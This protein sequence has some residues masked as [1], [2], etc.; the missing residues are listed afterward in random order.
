M[1]VP[2]TDDVNLPK[3]KA[4]KFTG[5]TA[6][7]LMFLQDDDNTADKDEADEVAGTYNGAMG[8]YRCDGDTACTVNIDA[9]GAITEIS[10]GWVFTPDPRV[11]SDVADANYLSYGFWLMK[12]TDEDGVLTYNEVETFAAVEGNEPTATTGLGA[13][14]GSA[15]YEGGSVGVY[16]KNVLYEQANITSATSGHFVADVELNAN[17]G[18]GGVAANDQFSIGG[19]ITNFVLQHGEENDWAV[20]LGL[21]DFSGG[22]KGDGAPGKSA[23]GNSHTN[24]FD[25]DATGDSTATAGTWNG[26]FYGESG[27]IDHDDEQATDPINTPPVAVIGEFNANFTDGTAAGGFGAN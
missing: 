21:A 27:Q 12:T 19:K 6:A 17:F 2:G 8:T 11:T 18:G 16:V 1:V 4:A 7:E 9:K 20:G 26:T 15:T 5:G 10:A 3:I 22:R 14:T 25:G 13:V 23:P 24:I